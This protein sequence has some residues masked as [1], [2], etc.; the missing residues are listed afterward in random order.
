[1]SVPDG[2]LILTDKELDF[3]APENG[4]RASAEITMP[5]DRPNWKDDVDLKFFYRLRDG[6]YGRMTFSMIAGG[7]HFCLIESFLNP[8]GSRNLELDPRR[9]VQSGRQ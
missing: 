6:R 8:S 9:A 5:A 4:Y 1:V 2:G 3:V 7:D